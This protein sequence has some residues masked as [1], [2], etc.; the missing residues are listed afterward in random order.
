MLAVPLL[1]DEVAPRFCSADEFLI[2]EVNRERVS[3]L[4]RLSL[5]EKAWS[6]RIEH[7]SSIGVRILL[8]SGFDRDF[9]PVAEGFGIQVI[10]GFAGVAEGLVEAFAKD[11]LEKFRFVPCARV[12]R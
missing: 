10:S 12:H 8:C 4:R 5:A 11:E 9:L 6:R 1:G 7:L 2:A 3:R